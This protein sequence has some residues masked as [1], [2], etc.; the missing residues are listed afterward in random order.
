MKNKEEIKKYYNQA[1]SDGY[2]DINK[3]RVKIYEKQS[4]PFYFGFL[5][6]I[7]PISKESIVLEIGCGEGIIMRVLSDYVKE[8]HGVDISDVAIERAKKWLSDKKNFFLYINDNIDF[9]LNKQF[10]LIFEATVFQHMLKDHVVEYI[11]Q[12]F[13][14]LKDDGHVMFQIIDD[15]LYSEV[16][17]SCEGKGYENKSSWKKEEFINVLKNKGFEV[18]SF[19]THDLSFLIKVSQS[20]PFLKSYYVIARKAIK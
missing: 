3:R 5:D 10:D 9:F 2:D 8:I 16:E 13:N 18:V 11:G 7:K 19:N 17:G 6:Y 20:R 12:C 14:R 1:Y 4:L 15:P